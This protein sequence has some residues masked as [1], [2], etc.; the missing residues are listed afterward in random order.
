[1]NLSIFK[2]LSFLG[3]LKEF[4]IELNVPVN[5]IA[6]EPDTAQNILKSNYRNT[7]AFHLMDDV[8]F[9]G[10]VDD[11][12]FG[13]KESIDTKK[14][15]TDY[16]GLLIFG[17]I[18]KCREKGYKP[19]RGQLSEI[20]RA[21]NR[22][23]HYTPVVV[24]FMYDGHIAF[25]NTE[26]LKYKQTWREGEKTGKVSLI[27]DIE[28]ENTHRGHISI[29]NQ[30]KIPQA[31]RGAINSFSQLYYYWQSVFSISVLNK[32]FYQEIIQ[33]FN[34]AINDIK[35]PSEISGSEK[36]KDFTVRLIARL[37][38]IWFLK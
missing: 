27:K 13:G 3:A 21:F 36:H 35:I 1:M 30:L 31:G 38:F 19:T 12:A 15:K 28:I 2:Q 23:F 22:E 32:V 4:F 9:L 5:Y 34:L 7:E 10:M 24:V 8:Y 33:W 18:L 26:R 37:I 14:I 29:L 6:E 11:A 25:A 20:T 16:D 17:V